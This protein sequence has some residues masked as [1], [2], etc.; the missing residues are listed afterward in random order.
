MR[1]SVRKYHVDECVVFKSTKSTFGGLSNMAPG[2]P[3]TAYGMWIRNAEALY[4][5]LRFPDYPEIQKIILQINSPITAKKYGRKCIDKTR[6]DWESHRFG[7]MRFCIAVKL[8]QNKESFSKILKST[9]GKSIVEYSDKDKV[10]G[11]LKIGEY[12]EGTNA[13]G[14]LLMELREKVMND[15]FELEIPQIPNFRLI[16]NVIKKEDFNNLSRFMPPKQ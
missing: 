8:E 9:E 5:A 16:G 14:R 4:Q 11:A 12:Y 7:I 1:Y 3:I 15:K 10:W 13:L 2:F 6:E